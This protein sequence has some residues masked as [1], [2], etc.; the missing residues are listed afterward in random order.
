MIFEGYEYYILFLAGFFSGAINTVAGGGSLLTLPILIFMGLP[1]TVA[2]GTNRIQLIFAQF[3][4]VYGYKSKGLFE[5]KLSIWLAFS[6]IQTI[7]I[8]Q[9]EKLTQNY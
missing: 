4:A 9:Y 6:A 5:Y 3:F 2:N 1:P 8:Q 7:L